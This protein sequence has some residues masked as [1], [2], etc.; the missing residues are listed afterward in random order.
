MVHV[1]LARQDWQ[2]GKLALQPLVEYWVDGRD[3]RI[4]GKADYIGLDVP[5]LDVQ[6]GRRVLFHEDPEAWARNLP[7]AY[8]AGDIVAEVLDPTPASR[9]KVLAGAGAGS[10]RRGR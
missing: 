2:A 4:E 6:S 3:V 10:V 1:R 8:R 5:V 7:N 9:Q